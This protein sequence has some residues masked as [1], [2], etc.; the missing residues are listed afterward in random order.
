MLLMHAGLRHGSVCA[1]AFGYLSHLA[2]DML[3]PQGL[4]LAWPMRH[5]WGIPLCRTGSPAESI[6]VL[7]LSFALVWWGVRHGS[8]TSWR[9]LLGPLWH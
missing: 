9:A 2:A 1:L 6:I 4:R 7:T 3:T 8:V 5:T